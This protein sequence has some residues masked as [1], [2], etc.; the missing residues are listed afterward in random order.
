[1]AKRADAPR[2]AQLWDDAAFL[3][4]VAA[5]AAER[6]RSLRDISLSSGMG[7]DYLNRPA[8][9]SGRSI[10]ALLRIAAELNLPIC[11]LLG[12][13]HD[14]PPRPRIDNETASRLGFAADVA[15]HLYVA[16]IARDEVKDADTAIGI[17]EALMRV[18][19]DRNLGERLDAAPE[20]R[21]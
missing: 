4:R 12:I 9:R 13:Q 17:V 5:I 19:K 10:E 14:R 1:M 18:I 16:M 20:L 11:D 7:H 15:A 3:R 8:P 6:G 2:P 21:E